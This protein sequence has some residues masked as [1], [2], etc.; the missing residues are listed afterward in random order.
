MKKYIEMGI[1]NT[2]FVRTEF[3]NEDGTEYEVRGVAGPI[4]PTSVYLRLWIGRKVYILD[5]REGFKRQ[6]KNRK[7][8]K[9]IFGM[10]S[11]VE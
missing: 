4:K 7:A 6:V 10:A 8:F 1:G 2:W 9:F 11:K 5:L 3:E